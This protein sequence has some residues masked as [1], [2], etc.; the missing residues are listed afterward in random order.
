[1][2]CCIDITKLT[3]EELL[4]YLAIEVGLNARGMGT[5]EMRVYIVNLTAEILYRMDK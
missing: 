3:N 4:K 1:M 5:V 2:A